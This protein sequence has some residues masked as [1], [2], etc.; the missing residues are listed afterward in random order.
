MDNQMTDQAQAPAVQKRR[1]IKEL[2]VS[3]QTQDVFRAILP[4]HFTPERMIRISIAAVT[5]TPKLAECHPMTLLGAFIECGVLGFE[6][7]S[8]LQ[9][10][11]LL[12]FWNSKA[13]CYEITRIIGYRG[14]IDL[15]YRTGKQ[16]SLHAD[17]VYEG[18]DFDFSY[19]SDTFIRHRPDLARPGDAKPRASY[20]H[21]KLADG[22]AFLVVPWSGVLDAR[23]RSKAKNSGPWVT[24][25]D[26]MA[27]KTAIRRLYGGGEVPMS[28]EMASA[29]TVD[30]QPMD[31]AALANARVDE[32]R[33]ALG[34]FAGEQGQEPGDDPMDRVVARN[35]PTQISSA[36]AAPDGAAAASQASEPQAQQASADPSDGKET[37]NVGG[38][39]YVQQGRACN[40][41]IELVS[42]APHNRLEHFSDPDHVFG[43]V[44][45]RLEEK[46]RDRIAEA[47]QE[48]RQELIE[49]NTG[50]AESPA[51]QEQDRGTGTSEPPPGTS[52][53]PDA[54]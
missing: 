27:R 52:L 38:K 50:L 20:C 36:T 46:H 41:L 42:V 24:D 8:P 48:R 29:V 4:R 22:Q 12:P 47:V 33:E 11:H 3:S 17:V 49:Q 15:A 2:L 39:A 51:E 16:I 7:N 43:D 53:F 9:H 6:P 26:R 54:A 45:A 21:V 44:V 28:I 34:S 35:R 30:E 13:N 25:L 23:D 5:R 37:Y 32:I 40:A 10:V 1:D 31:Y 18:D 19:G 14:Y